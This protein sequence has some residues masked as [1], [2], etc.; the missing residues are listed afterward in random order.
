MS[1]NYLPYPRS[2]PLAHYE[3]VK[4]ALV[5]MNC[6]YHQQYYRPLATNGSARVVR[7]LMGT[8]NNSPH[9]NQYTFNHNANDFLAPQGVA[10]NSVGIIG[11][12]EQARF[13]WYMEIRDNTPG[14]NARYGII[15][16][17]NHVGYGAMSQSLD[18]NMEMYFNT[19][20]KFDDQMRRMPNGQV[21]MKSRL[22]NCSNVLM[23]PGLLNPQ[24]GFNRIPYQT[25]NPSDVASAMAVYEMTD[26][27]T[28]GSVINTPNQF[29]GHRRIVLSDMTNQVASKY[30]G[31]V[32]SNTYNTANRIAT[33][34]HGEPVDTP[35][36]YSGL[37]AGM[38]TEAMHTHNV[39]FIAEMEKRFNL[40]IKPFLKFS[41]LK[42]LFPAINDDHIGVINVLKPQQRVSGQHLNTQQFSGSSPEV[43]TAFSIATAVPALMLSVGLLDVGFTASNMS[44]TGEWMI[45]VA[46]DVASGSRPRAVNEDLSI[47]DIFNYFAEKLK[48]ELLY[49]LSAGG[50]AELNMQV[51][52]DVQGEIKILLQMNGGLWT[53]FAQPAFCS[54]SYSPLLATDS[55][56]IES[57]A[58]DFIHLRD[59]C[60]LSFD[61]ITMNQTDHISLAS[62]L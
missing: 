6:G 44:V 25:I 48:Q 56:R 53:P 28:R 39:D 45:H 36:E 29:T 47:E 11:G 52:C 16:F 4:F 31:K 12:W 30:L 18:P 22:L 41:E 60:G 27:P 5:E 59:A 10:G 3:V 8:W 57:M 24:H 14:Y 50:H 62:L 9:K 42:S 46:F 13:M 2:Q 17:T 35:S 43:V 26:Y 20:L 21:R 19:I 38:L 37:V 7:D 23:N 54:A 32:M 40:G 61:A 51:F 58:N 49:G 15:G 33:D 55:S 1:N 34:P